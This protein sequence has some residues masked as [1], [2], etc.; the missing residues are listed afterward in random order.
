MKKITL[1]LLTVFLSLANLYADKLTDIK[2]KGTITVGIYGNEEPFSF[3][4]RS[5]KT[6]GFNVDLMEY[7]SKELGLKLEFKKINKRKIEKNI[8]GNHVDIIV[9][10]IVHTLKLDQ[11]LDFTI[12]YFYNGQ[13][14][15]VG[16]KDSSKNYKDFS[17]KKVAAVK[18][19]RGKTF[20]FIEPLADIVYFDTYDKALNALKSKKVAA[21]TD[22]YATLSR[23]AVKNKT[24]VKML[25]RPFTLE[26]YGMILRENQSNLRD[27]LNRLI[28]KSVKSGEYEKLYKKWFNKTA[29]KEPT[30]WP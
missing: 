7:I 24:K 9:A 1:V 12:S 8:L 19:K 6:I 27:E 10:P 14:L 4:S 13:S 30:L 25:G 29:F 28:Q 2:R 11:R 18:D 22:D 15:L 26:P 20:K 21:I 17:L 23:M 5:G 16:K 3:K